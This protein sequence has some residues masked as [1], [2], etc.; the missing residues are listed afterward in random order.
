MARLATLPAGGLEEVVGLPVHQLR[1]K[2]A[3]LLLHLP[4]LGVEALPDVGELRVDDAEV[5]HLDGDVLA[6][7]HF[8][9]VGFWEI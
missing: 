6:V 8:D 4:H 3:H 9:L 5:A 7:R 2:L 1:P